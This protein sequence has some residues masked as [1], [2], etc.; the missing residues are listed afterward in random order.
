M[1]LVVLSSCRKILDIEVEDTEAKYVIEAN[2]KEGQHDF[3]VNISKTSS[4]FDLGKGPNVDN[5]T[6]VLTD[7]SGVMTP[8]PFIGNGQYMVN[9]NAVS[10]SQYDL[11]VTIGSF[12]YDASSF[13]PEPIPLVEIDTTFI[14]ATGPIPEGYQ[15]FLRYQDPVN[16]SNYYRILHT[17]N[18]T[19]QNDGS[20]LQVVD[21]AI[22]DGVFTRLPIFGKIFDSG[23]KVFIELR[24]IDKSGYDYFDAL[25]DIIGDGG[26]SA[27]PGNPDNNWS[28]DALGH[29]STYSSDTLS[30]KLP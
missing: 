9:I 25:L 29:F 10:N 30:I 17:L 12:Q 5:A 13:M 19:L 28:G 15:V 14:E 22:Y 24:H 18:D 20:D 11:S 2:L 21:D 6:V 8:V 4:Y 27:A 23:D 16:V 7:A 1:T 3:I 26:G